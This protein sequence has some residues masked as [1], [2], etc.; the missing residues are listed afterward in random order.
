MVSIKSKNEKEGIFRG[1]VTLTVSVVIVK[2]I[3]FIYKV[4]LSH[5]LTD[6][7]MGYFNSAYSIFT[8]FYMI[9]LGGVPRAIAIAVSKV[10]A[11]GK[12]EE[13]LKILSLAFKI[14]VG[15]GVVFTIILMLFSQIFASFIGSPLSAFSILTIAPSL[16]FVSAAG[17][18]RGYMNGCG[19]M[20]PI[21]ISEVLDGAIKFV[22]GLL[23]A[24]I[25]V[26]QNMSY[27]IISAFAV[28]GVTIGT[29]IGTLFLYISFK[30]ENKGYIIKQNARDCDDY[31][32]IIKNILITSLPIT[33]SSAIMSLSN[34]IDLGMIM[35]RLIASGF[36]EVEAVTLFGNFTTLVLPFLNA[37]SSFTA[38]ISTSAIPHLAKQKA[39]GDKASYNELSDTIFS[40]VGLIVVPISFAFIL[41][42]YEILTFLFEDSSAKIAAPLLSVIAPA[43]VFLPL[44]TISNSILES[45]SLE[46]LPLI[47]M[48]MGA[49]LKFSIG[50]FSIEKM[51]ISGAAIGTVV[52]YGVALFISLFFI[53]Y[54]T[55][56]E[57]SI[58]RY[59][60]K[61]LLS[62]FVS[63]FGVYTLNNYCIYK[64]GKSLGFISILV[65][66]VVVYSAFICIFMQKKIKNVIE[67][68][69]IAKKADC[70]L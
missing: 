39:I 7:G 66:C 9:C 62:S 12:E 24:L 31:G 42:P 51:G 58:F 54:K 69:K 64:N 43:V 50:Y 17:V 26:R 57:I 18:L 56:V 32:K 52:C 2:I 68:V 65:L 16:T 60:F 14:F 33:L 41:F 8:F 44:L 48:S 67:Y 36:S 1:A 45:S 47:S 3:G 61:P 22:V 15:A 40:L 38:P 59:L 11:S 28:L 13:A 29:F 19:K 23:F 4:P 70:S 25:A 34:I 35:K 30:I 63:I 21:A 49:L 6:E 37:V 5:V 55:D 27:Y 53:R 10:K 46:R 20:L